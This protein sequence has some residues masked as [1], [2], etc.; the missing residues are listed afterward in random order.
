MTILETSPNGNLRL[1]LMKNGK[2][3]VELANYDR[4]NWVWCVWRS[5]PL[6]E[7]QKLF[8]SQVRFHQAS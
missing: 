5:L 7:A 2:G 3:V 8:D 6:D 4:S 1:R